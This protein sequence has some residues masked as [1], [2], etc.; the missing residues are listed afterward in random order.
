MLNAVTVG[1]VIALLG[2]VLYVNSASAYYPV[3]EPEYDYR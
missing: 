1:M 2:A 3:S